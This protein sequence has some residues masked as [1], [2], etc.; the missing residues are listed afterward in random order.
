VLGFV[1]H[2]LR[3]QGYQR[4]EIIVKDARFATELTSSVSISVRSSHSHLKTQ[5]A[6]NAVNYVSL[7]NVQRMLA[8]L[9]LTAAENACTCN[10][11]VFQISAYT[12][13]IEMNILLN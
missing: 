6:R 5:D 7:Q 1:G 4:V 3:K 8:E 10:V 9:T 12:T 13:D 11:S 2:I